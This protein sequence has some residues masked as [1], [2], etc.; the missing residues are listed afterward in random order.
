MAKI[1]LLN[2]QKFDNV[3]NIE[4]FK[5]EFLKPQTDLSKYDALIFTSKNAV[6]SL[7]SLDKRWKNISSFAIAKKTSDIIIEEGGKVEFSGSSGHGNDFANELIPL[8]KSRKVLYVRAE[9][10]V[11]SLVKILRDSNINIDELITYKTVCNDELNM[12]LE[13]NSTIIFTSPSSIKC[14]FKKFQWDESFKAIVI[15]RTTAKYLPDYVNFKL[16]SKTSV[17]ECI[18]LA[19]LDSF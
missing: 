18:K 19:L 4:V 13:K 2:N 1:Y 17:E 5:I 16:S 3:E 12:V 10:V 9:E 6:Y 14:F 7:N 15:G 11:S 8:L